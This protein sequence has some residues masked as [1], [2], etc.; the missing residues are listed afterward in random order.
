MVGHGAGLLCDCDAC[1]VQ[2]G[3]SCLLKASQNGHLDVVKHLCEVG[4]E[5]LLMLTD[6]VRGRVA[7]LLC[8]YV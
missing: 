1:I 6:K 2:N 4:G 5:T 3:W 8:V 7:V